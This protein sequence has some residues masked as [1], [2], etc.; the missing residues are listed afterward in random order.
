MVMNVSI[1]PVIVLPKIVSRDFLRHQYSSAG[2]CLRLR[3]VT[4]RESPKCEFSSLL[5]YMSSN[6]SAEFK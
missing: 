6:S 4:S 5:T 1:I 2:A 3:N